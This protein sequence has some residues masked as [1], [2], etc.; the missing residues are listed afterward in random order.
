MP[1]LRVSRECFTSI[2]YAAQ[3]S[4]LRLKLGGNINCLNG[5]TN[6]LRSDVLK[7]V[8]RTPIR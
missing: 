6:G 8:D 5:G 1:R 3:S 4:K 7:S 2:S